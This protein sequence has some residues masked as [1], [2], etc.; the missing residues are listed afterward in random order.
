MNCERKSSQNELKYYRFYVKHRSK[1][2]ESISR[3]SIRNRTY[4]FI[5]SVRYVR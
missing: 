2:L 4:L 1:N 5:V 3:L